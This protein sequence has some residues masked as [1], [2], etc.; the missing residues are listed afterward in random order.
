MKILETVSLMQLSSKKGASGFQ[1]TGEL[2]AFV[3]RMEEKLLRMERNLDAYITQLATASARLL[4]ATALAAKGGRKPAAH[5]VVLVDT[6]TGLGQNQLDKPIKISAQEK[7][8]IEKHAACMDEWRVLRNDLE[9]GYASARIMSQD[10]ET[11]EKALQGMI[12]AITRKMEEAKKAHEKV[13]AGKIP[14]RFKDIAS[15]YRKKLSNEFMFSNMKEGK[16]LSFVTDELLFHYTISARQVGEDSSKEWD[17]ASIVLTYR[18]KAKTGKPES[19]VGL[20]VSSESILPKDIRRPFH[21]KARTADELIQATREEME[22]FGIKP[23]SG[24]SPI[25]MEAFTIRKGWKQ[26]TSKVHMLDESTMR[27]LIS[28]KYATTD[29]AGRI[30]QDVAD[31]VRTYYPM[32][33]M[34]ASE[35]LSTGKGRE[36]VFSFFLKKGETYREAEDVV[37]MLGDL[38]D[39]DA[40]TKQRMRKTL[41][42]ESGLIKPRT[43]DGPK[44]RRRGQGVIQPKPSRR[45]VGTRTT[46]PPTS[47][48]TSPVTEQK[49]EQPRRPGRKPSGSSPPAPRPKPKPKPRPRPS[50]LQLQTQFTRA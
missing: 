2:N 11:E 42:S 7:K 6:R 12:A 3:K 20:Y 19:D 46:K 32:Y 34:N 1:S 50:G 16:M 5:E 47:L 13:F 36:V 38:Y 37:D 23:R 24:S 10:T 22:T 15:E 44:R 28:Q 31:V 33:T 41:L 27:V 17:S 9:S 30:I 18:V 48:E 39:W 26:W 40:A 49:T 43:T 8:D 25:D 29:T 4:P 14:S 21:R 35:N 45:R